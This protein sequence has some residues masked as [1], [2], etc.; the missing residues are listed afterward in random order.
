[1]KKKRRRVGQHNPPNRPKGR[2]KNRLN[3][4]DYALRR[5]GGQECPPYGLICC[6]FSRHFG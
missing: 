5:I 2:N 4:K 6:R 3:S 1:M